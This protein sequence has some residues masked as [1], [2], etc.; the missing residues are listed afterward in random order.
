MFSSFSDFA[1]I[2]LKA[3]SVKLSLD[4]LTPGVD[5]IRH[6]VL[7][8]PD[9]C[10]SSSKLIYTLFLKHAKAKKILNLD[11]TTSL[12][13]ARDEFKHL[14]RNVLH[15]AINQAK[16]ASEN[17]ID[18]LAQITIVKQLA[19]E[20]RCQYNSLIENFNDTVR[21]H[22]ISSNE[23]L[24]SYIKI[25]EKLSDIQQNKKSISLNVAAELFQYLIEVQHENIT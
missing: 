23:G 11:P 4:R 20:I 3:Y 21:R 5:N 25:K 1:G 18:L 14:C 9:F 16:S 17:Q 24:N 10:K 6:D 13:T 19:Q 2:P 12:V 7:L 15:T 8:S 22:E